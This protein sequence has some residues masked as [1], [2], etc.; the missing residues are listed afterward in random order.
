MTASKSGS[1]PSLVPSL[2]PCD[3]FKIASWA[4]GRPIG[5]VMQ[6]HFSTDHIAPRDRV[7]FWCDYFAKQVA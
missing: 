7:R 5:V 4:F 1:T 2:Y 3:Q 6:V